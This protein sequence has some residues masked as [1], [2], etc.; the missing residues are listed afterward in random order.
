M[1]KFE[2]MSLKLERSI[3]DIFRLDYVKKEFDKQLTQL[4][5]EGWKHSRDVKMVSWL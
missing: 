3:S 2:Y 1:A 5:E 4:G